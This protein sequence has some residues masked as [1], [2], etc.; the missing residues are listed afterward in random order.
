[1]FRLLKMFIKHEY[2]D[3]SSNTAKAFAYAFLA[4]I[5]LFVL[6]MAGSFM[7]MLARH[8]PEQAIQIINEYGLLLLSLVLLIFTIPLVF[9]RLFSDSDLELLFTL[10]IKVKDIFWAKFLL[11]LL[12]V[13]IIAYG[14]AVFCLTVFGV[15]AGAS[16]FYYPISYIVTFFFIILSISLAYLINL[17]LIQLIP[18]TKAKELLTAVSALTGIIFYLGFQLLNVNFFSHDGNMDWNQL[19]GIPE[20]LPMH[21][22]AVIITDSILGE[23]QM[24]TVIM[25][26][27]LIIL[28]LF[29]FWISSI[30]VEKALLTGW[31]NLS[32]SSGRK[33]KNQ[34]RINKKATIYGPIRMIS[35]KEWLM[36]KR[37]VREWTAVIPMLV[38]IIFPFLN[39]RDFEGGWSALQQAPYITW[40]TLQ[41][42]FCFMAVL[43]SGIFSAGSLGREAY[44]IDL[45]RVLPLSGWKVA[46]G[47]FWANVVIMT[48]FVAVV[49]IVS[50]MI[51]NWSVL[52][53]F[54]GWLGITG[55]LVG[56]VAI[57]LFI[58]SIGSKYNPKNPQNRVDTGSSIIMMMMLFFYLFIVSVP[59]ALTFFPNE[60]LSDILNAAESEH[61]I[62][63]FFIGFLEGSLASG[64]WSNL[65]GLAIYLVMIGFVTWGSLAICAKNIDKGVNITFEDK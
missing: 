13:P 60:Y 30:L 61:G 5:G 41:V 33:K 59:T 16:F 15:S 10:P 58:S 7:M 45:L 47:K 29:I 43:V 54:L 65:I 18:P 44:A 40:P 50:G 17:L 8:A 53:I 3:L 55:V 14:F 37:D 25:L 62:P 2:R 63:S 56:A 52:S 6:F 20:W 26:L 12:G 42:S 32:E 31:V 27:F 9:N 11:N 1:M 24:Q 19:A 23:W 35:K 34:K 39:L 22:G 21:W 28:T 51:L 46:V 38:I 57:G 64:L 48:A 49:Q 36:I 4:L